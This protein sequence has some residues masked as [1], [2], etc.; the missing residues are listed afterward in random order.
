MNNG[1]RTLTTVLVTGFMAVA[2]FAGG[3]V[4][5]HYTALPDSPVFT[6]AGLRDLTVNP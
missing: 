6:L 5:G 3:F 2:V 4:A 1:V